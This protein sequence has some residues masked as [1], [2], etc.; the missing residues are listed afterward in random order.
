M[1]KYPV[2]KDFRFLPGGM[3][4]QN[5]VVLKLMRFLVRRSS[6]PG[7]PSI[8]LV[9]RELVQVA[10]DDGTSIKALWIAPKNTPV[11]RGVIVY[12]PGGGYVLPAGGA[13]LELCDQYVAQSGFCCLFINYRLAPEFLFPLGF[14]D[15]Y[16]GL[17]YAL[18]RARQLDIEPSRVVVMGDSAGGALAAGVAQKALDRGHRLGAQMLMYPAIDCRC[19]TESAQKY[20]DTPIWNGQ[21]NRRMWSLYLGDFQGDAIPKYASPAERQDLLGLAKAYI[22]PAEF[23]PLVDEAIEYANRLKAHGVDV[24]LNRTQGTVHG[25]DQFAKQNELRGDAISRRVRF[26]K[27]VAEI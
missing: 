18:D 5:A 23:D 26:L 19:T 8:D 12:F 11:P 9:T 25:F 17:E 22:E 24:V 6:L 15:C 20:L 1:A 2:H 7:N 16:T 21:C 10:R 13:H 4:F 14:N 3:F 27:N